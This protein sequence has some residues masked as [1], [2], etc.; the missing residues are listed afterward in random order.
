[1][2]NRLKMTFVDTH[3]HL[4]VKQFDEDQSEMIERAIAQKIEIMLL[5]NIDSSTI[6][7]MIALEK[8]FPRNCHAMMGLHPCSVKEDFQSELQVVKE[9]LEKRS[10]CAIGEMGLDLHWDQTFYEQQKLAFTQ[11]C[12][13]AYDLDLPIVIHS[14]KAT[15]EA[16]DLLKQ[17]GLRRPKGVFHC[18]GGTLDEAKQI[19]DMGFYMGIGGVVTFKNGGLKEILSQIPL[20]SVVL[21]TDSPYLAPTPFRGKRN[22]SAYIRQIATTIA[23]IYK[24]EEEIIAKVTTENAKKLFPKV[25][26][27]EEDKSTDK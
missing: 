15:Q 8:K 5:P 6:D 14:R 7:S 12:E 11:Q 18:F 26:G 19:M 4:F 21:E 9:W 13:W 20:T 10:F 24:T 2:F 16:I 22:E 25:F 1:M 17:M 27:N 23:S 3:T